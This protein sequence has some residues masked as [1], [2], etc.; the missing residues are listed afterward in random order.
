LWD[1]RGVEPK[2]INELQVGPAYVEDICFSTD[3]KVL[4]AVSNPGGFRVWTMDG[5]VARQIAAVATGAS[6]HAHVAFSHDVHCL[7][8]AGFYLLDGKKI[9]VTLYDLIGKEPRLRRNVTWHL[10][11]GWV[12][13]G[14]M[15]RLAFS[16]DD[17]Q[18]LLA[19]EDEMFVLDT[20][21]GQKL[22]H[23]RFSG[24]LL[25]ADFAPDGRHAAVV[26]GDGTIYI[27]RLPDLTGKSHAK[28][29]I[30][31]S[32]WSLLS[33]VADWL[34]PAV[35]LSYSGEGL[36]ASIITRDRRDGRTPGSR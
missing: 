31:E 26:N 5:A 12:G 11:T 1:V 20:Y 29:G 10:D 30:T 16:P 8:Y 7:V 35:F 13:G 25:D 15:A 18:L 24:R 9:S 28:E 27:L 2:K 4:A 3:G 34:Y 23:R 14:P 6:I 21:T 33:S 19:V 36:G 17:Q 22:F 32:L